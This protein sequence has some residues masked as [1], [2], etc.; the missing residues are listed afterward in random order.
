MVES[1]PD[2]LLP[3]HTSLPPTHLLTQRTKL[4]LGMLSEEIT[5]CN[6]QFILTINTGQSD[7][8][9]LK[10]LHSILFTHIS[11]VC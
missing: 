10:P 4:C 6:P 9:I 7:K 2:V 11:T 1:G 8:V 3:D 5:L